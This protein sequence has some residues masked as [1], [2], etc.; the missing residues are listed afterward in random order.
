MELA[1]SL[2]GEGT[3]DLSFGEQ[4]ALLLRLKGEWMHQQARKGEQH[5]LFDPL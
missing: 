5:S 2:G 4:L 3:S 1:E